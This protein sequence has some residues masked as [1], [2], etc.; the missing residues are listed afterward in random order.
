[1]TSRLFFVA[2]YRYPVTLDVVF[3]V[4]RSSETKHHFDIV[5]VDQLE[6]QNGKT[7]LDFDFSKLTLGY[8][9]SIGVKQDVCI[10]VCWVVNG[11][12]QHT[13]LLRSRVQRLLKVLLK[14]IVRLI[15]HF[16]GRL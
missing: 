10:L 11:P 8:S 2:T 1:M 6:Q 3:K 12:R 16:H 4:E 13:I 7:L 15:V 14:R 5:V 9:K